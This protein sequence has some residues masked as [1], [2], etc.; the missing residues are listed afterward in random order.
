MDQRTV[1]KVAYHLQ[2]YTLLKQDILSGKIAAGMRIN[3]YN[4]AKEFGVSRSPVREAVRMLERDGL[5]VPCSNGTMVNPLE[6]EAICEIYQARL[7]LESYAARDSVGRMGEAE[8]NVLEQCIQHCKQAHRKGDMQRVVQENTRFHEMV[9]SY[10]QNALIRDMI[11]RQRDLS[12]LAR[13]RE[14]ETYHKEDRYL[15]EHSEILQAIRSEDAD[16]VECRM[17]RHIGH[18]LD[19]Y[20]THLNA[21]HGKE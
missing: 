2:V 13:R 17:R 10:C 11:A 15:A 12:L 20:K 3:E 7:V 19:F 8:L 18:D 5:L 21:E 4:F 6:G 14:F 9:V 16:L 1:K